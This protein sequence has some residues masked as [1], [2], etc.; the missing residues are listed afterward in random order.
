M[1]S[2]TFCTVTNARRVRVKQSRDKTNTRKKGSPLRNRNVPSSSSR[3]F[4]DTRSAFSVAFEIKGILCVCRRQLLRLCKGVEDVYT[5][6]ICVLLANVQT[7]R[8]QGRPVFSC[9]TEAKIIISNPLCARVET[10]RIHALVFKY[11]DTVST[12][13]SSFLKSFGIFLL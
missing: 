10:E 5:G 3:S 2:L 6:K 4:Y 13:F 12:F 9:W 11:R 8:P 7:L 1:L